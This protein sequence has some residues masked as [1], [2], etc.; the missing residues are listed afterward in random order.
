MRL[1]EMGFKLG[2]GGAITY[3]RAVRLQGLVKQLPLESICLETDA[4][5]QPSIGYLGKRNEPLALIEVLDF[6]ARLRDT[7]PEIIAHQTSENTYAALNI[8]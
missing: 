5:D 1:I 3:P 6:I 2:F 4:P 8:C 7:E